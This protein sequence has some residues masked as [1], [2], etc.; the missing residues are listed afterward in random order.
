M[1][2]LPPLSPP[3]PAV[4]AVALLASSTTLWL[5]TLLP[6]AHAAFSAARCVAH[7]SLQQR[8]PAGAKEMVL[9]AVLF[10]QWCEHLQDTRW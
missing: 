6:K 10:S 1:V 8:S 2:G 9:G 4:P 3:P 7:I 5:R